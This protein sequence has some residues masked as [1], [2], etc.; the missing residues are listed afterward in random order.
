MKVLVSLCTRGRYENYL[1]MALL[2]LAMQT[3]KPDHIRI[4]DDNDTDKIIDIRTIPAINYVLLLLQ[5]K[6][7]GWD[8]EYGQKKGQHFN[9][10]RANT[11]G[12]DLIW[13]YDDDECAE[14]DC[15]ENLLKEMKDDVGA[16]GPLVL[17]PP[18]SN[19]LPENALNKI[20]DIYAPNMQWFCWEG[21]SKEVEHLHSSFLYRAGIAHFD[22][23][24]S[25]VSFR[26]ETMFTHELYM[27][28][29]KL[30]V[31]PSAKVWH[32]QSNTGGDR[33]EGEEK[34]RAELYSHDEN[35][36]NKWLAK[37]KISDDAKIIYLDNGLGDHIVFSTLLEE[38]KKKYGKLRIYCCYPGIFAGE[39]IRSVAEG[40]KIIPDVNK[41]NIYEWMWKHNWEDSLL[42]AFKKMYEI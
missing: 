15:L 7:I 40:M 22:L 1:P 17:Q 16:V 11:S 4:Y 32:F 29:Y 12:Y 5:E 3:H 21:E 14:P 39:D 41:Y 42:E 25:Q 23:S 38:L 36:F 28:G 35:I 24:L 27:K 34:K 2:S 30:I 10:E 19:K 33:T 8:L 6:E 37:N 18:A 9:D 31:A 13:R 20:A 26:G